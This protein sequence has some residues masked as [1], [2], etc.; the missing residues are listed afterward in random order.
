MFMRFYIILFAFVAMVSTQGKSQEIYSKL[1]TSVKEN[2]YIE[3]SE[4]RGKDITP[5]C[6]VE[7]KIQKYTLHG[8]KQ[9]GVD[10]IEVDNGMLTF[11]VVPTRGMGILEVVCDDVR[12]GW[13]SPIKEVVHPMYI[14]L[15]RRSGS[16]MLEGF[17]EF[18]MRCGIE[19]AG[20]PGTDT[21]LDFYE[22]EAEL[23]LT[24]HGKIQNTP[25]S[26]VQVLI[27]KEPPYRIS[28][29]GK[30]NECM[31]F[32]PQFE[33]WTEISTEPGSLSFRV[34][35]TITNHSVAEQEFQI[36]YHCNYG[37]SLVEAGSKFVAPLRQVTPANQ[38]TVKRLDHITD[39]LGPS[40]DNSQEE[41]NIQ[42]WGDDKGLTQV[43]LHNEK[44]DRGVS[45]SFSIEQLPYFVL[46]KNMAPVE[47]GYVT[48]LEPATGFAQNRRIQRHFGRVPKLGAGESRRFTIDFTFLNTKLDV[49]RIIDTIA[50]I[51][52]G[53]KTRIDPQPEKRP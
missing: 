24:L 19:F 21:Y 1:F 40:P 47:S 6:P 11:K 3:Q 25:A 50:G 14:D 32:G 36:I 45:M 20:D 33:L 26:E 53:R 12:L 31:F 29:R 37:S 46:W 34:D 2:V 41:F 18:L 35:D 43:M 38:I 39:Y 22:Q 4:L 51:Q 49:K 7:W 8:G 23:E 28:I 30:L 9:E 17:N 5:N 42:L 27:E 48:G 10:V 16:G 52:N 44:V 13:D 15:E